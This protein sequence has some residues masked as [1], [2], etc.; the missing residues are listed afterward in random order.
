MEAHKIVSRDEWLV[1]RKALLAKEKEHTRARDALSAERRALPWVKVEKEYVFDGPK[2][3]RHW[4]NCSPDAASSSSSTSC[5]VP[6]G[7]RAASAA[8]SRPIISTARCRISST[9]T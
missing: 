3:A 5:S 2:G 1:A 9:T 8:R 4:E 6:T 7:R